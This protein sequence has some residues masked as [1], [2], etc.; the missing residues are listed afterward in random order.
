MKFSEITIVLPTPEPGTVPDKPYI[1]L[2]RPKDRANLEIALAPADGAKSVKHGL[3]L[4]DLF[5]R[6]KITYVDCAR[7]FDII[8]KKKGK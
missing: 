2:S 4:V 6:L 7:A 3:S 8:D 5:E 1:T